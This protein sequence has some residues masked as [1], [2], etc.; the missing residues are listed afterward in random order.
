MTY[1]IRRFFSTRWNCPGGY[2]EVLVLAFPLIIS[3]G[4]LSIQQF[5]DRMFLTWYSPETIA[6]SAP[7]GMLNFTLLSIFIGT[8][9]YVTTFVAQYNGARNYDRIGHIVWQGLYIA[10]IA[11]LFHLLLLP[12]AGFLFSVIGHDAAVQVQEIR[13]FQVLCLSAAPVV[14]S[15]AL[16][17]FFSGRSITWPVMWV[18]II[19]TM[20]NIV[21][22]YGLIFGRFG[23]PEMGITGA[24]IATVLSAVTSMSLFLILLIQ[25]EN[26]KHFHSLSGWRYDSTLFKR[27]IR[28][29][30]PNGI[31]FLLDMAGFTVFIL[32]VGRIGTVYLAATNIAFNINTIAFMPML[33]AGI[34]VSILVGQY[35]G[36]GHPDI[37]ERSAFSAFHLTTVYMGAISALYLVVPGL[38]IKPFT[39]QAAGS[40]FAAIGGITAIL[41]RFLAFYCVFDALNI[42]GASA[43]K[44]AGD[45]R[46]VMVAIALFSLF[47]LVI[48]SIIAIQ[49]FHAD[50]YI[51]WTIATIYITLL[52]IMFFLRFLGGK[53]KSMRVIE[54]MPPSI[55][56]VLPEAPSLDIE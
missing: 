11:G 33:G 34:A 7:A 55:P 40:E 49:V 50:I 30:L 36:K 16:A 43:I 8:A 27:L 5:I 54:T 25:R 6:A 37:A 46:F 26:R 32:L 9:S 39:L 24:A 45:T 20:V 44:G 1:Y 21:L 2:R 56:T 23:L 12:T 3:T 29:G 38:F 47:L 31:Q 35:I 52:G 14:A 18:N 13:Y 19:A 42:I 15:S 22:D 17:G 41:L 53:W 51:A 48:P 28:F 4:S 10:V